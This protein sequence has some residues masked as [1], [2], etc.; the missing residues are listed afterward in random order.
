MQGEDG[1]AFSVFGR[2]DGSDVG[3]RDEIFGRV[4][5]H[6]LPVA[7]RRRHRGA[8]DADV[9]NHPLQKQE[10]IDDVIRS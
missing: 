5:A 6:R 9:K 3:D 1:L 10:N 7:D 2:C 4:R 8:E